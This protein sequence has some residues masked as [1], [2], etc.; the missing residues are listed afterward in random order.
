MAKRHEFDA[1]SLYAD[2]MA[3]AEFALANNKCYELGGEDPVNGIDCSGLALY[4]L[5]RCGFST[6][7]QYLTLQNPWGD[8]D[9]RLLAPDICRLLFTRPLNW[10]AHNANVLGRSSGPTGPDPRFGDFGYMFR[11]YYYNTTPALDHIVL[12]FGREFVIES[13]SGMFGDEGAFERAQGVSVSA[14][15][16]FTF[17]FGTTNSV[18]RRVKRNGVRV[19]HASQYPSPGYT[20]PLWLDYDAYNKWFRGPHGNVK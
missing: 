10:N 11:A 3:A 20:N 5:S 16:P 6:A 2:W 15:V 4:I 17:E 8:G 19:R 7:N 13:T 1:A 18:T 9:P 12:G 14:E